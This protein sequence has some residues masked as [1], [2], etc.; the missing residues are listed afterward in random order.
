MPD[1]KGVKQGDWLAVV[2]ADGSVAFVSKA[3]RIGAREI[4]TEGFAR[5]RISD[6]VG[7][8]VPFGSDV[9]VPSTA[10]P[11]TEAEVNA[12]L[13]RQK[14]REG[15]SAIRFAE[16]VLKS[17]ESEAASLARQALELSARIDDSQAK[18]A[19]LRKQLA[20]AQAA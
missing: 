4:R 9:G 7:V 3:D 19:E 17:K 10:R 5:Y 15:E 13:L 18:L 1:L 12:H 14:I 16:S 2:R 11:A 20:E 6:G 8:G